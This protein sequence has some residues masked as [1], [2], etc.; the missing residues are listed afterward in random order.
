MSCRNLLGLLERRSTFLDGLETESWCPA[1][2]PTAVAGL[3]E[4]PNSRRSHQMAQG[5]A[6]SG[7]FLKP[8]TGTSPL[9]LAPAAVERH[10]MQPLT[11]S[12]RPTAA[13]ESHHLAL[14]CLETRQPAPSLCMLA[15]WFHLCLLMRVVVSTHRAVPR[16]IWCG[17][18]CCRL[19]FTGL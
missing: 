17:P 15:L 5:S 2:I 7:N 13:V 9:V 6:G 12:R 1:S 16:R 10:I 18:F 19:R 11:R 14:S 3:A 4:W 8:P